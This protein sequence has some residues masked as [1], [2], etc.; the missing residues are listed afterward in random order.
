[1]DSFK[2]FPDQLIN[3]NNQKKSSNFEKLTY[4]ANVID[5]N[6]ILQWECIQQFG[7]CDFENL[8]SL[9][10]ELL[11]FKSRK[12]IIRELERIKAFAS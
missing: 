12:A 1:M 11:Y 10:Q 2:N 6:H 4:L 8:K 7:H 9:D 3:V 5:C